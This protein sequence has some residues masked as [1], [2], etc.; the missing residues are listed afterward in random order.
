[1]LVMNLAAMTAVRTPR[2]T[3]G[4]LR[5]EVVNALA[6]PSGQ[7]RLAAER[8]PRMG[9]TCGRSIREIQASRITSLSGVA[10]A[11]TAREIKTAR[12]GAGSGACSPAALNLGQDRLRLVWREP[13]WLAPNGRWTNT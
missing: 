10:K 7:E 4:K 2:P 13:K 8:H 9:I 6:L 1:M 11:L 3:V 5:D 12:A